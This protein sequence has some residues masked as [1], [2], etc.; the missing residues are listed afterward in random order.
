MENT[1]TFSNTKL[2]VLLVADVGRA[3]YIEPTIPGPV[4]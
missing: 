3:A 1:V 4:R 2:I